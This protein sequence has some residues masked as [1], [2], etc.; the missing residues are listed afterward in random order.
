MKLS[1]FIHLRSIFLDVDVDSKKNLFKEV[2]KSLEKLEKINSADI[3]EKL[4]KRERLGST[5]VGNGAAIPHAKINNLKKTEVF[6]YKL[7]KPIEFSSPDEL[8]VDLIFVIVTPES[9]QSEHL[10]MLSSISSFLKNKKAVLSLRKEKNLGEI[11]KVFSK[12]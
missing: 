3:V 5:G 11:L 4:N 8:P 1:E 9:S 7:I 10:L 6:F 2:G 12:Y